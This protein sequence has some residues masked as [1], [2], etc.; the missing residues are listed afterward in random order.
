MGVSFVPGRVD[1]RPELVRRR[2]A[3]PDACPVRH[4]RR[5]HV[6]VVA[7]SAAVAGLAVAI[8]R[9]TI[10]VGA[11]VAVA[12]LVP[13]AAI[14]IERRRLPDVWIGSALVALVAARSIESATGRI[15][16][17]GS[18]SGSIAGALAMAIPILLLHLVSPE[19]MGFGDVK[20]AVVLGAAVG[21]VDWR[22]GAVALCVA[23]GTGS[24]SGVLTR[25]RTIAFGPFLVLGAGGV[26]VAHERILGTLFNGSA[27]T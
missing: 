7:A 2:R 20:A 27:G 18:I 16:D 4:D 25:S 24:I 23:A 21:T 13:A 6:L 19:S 15:G 14:D 22:L 10:P 12:V 3:A 9:G 11:G 17:A 26:L 5:R 8:V 1:A